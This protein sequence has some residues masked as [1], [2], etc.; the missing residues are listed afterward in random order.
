MVV[1]LDIGY[2]EVKV[3]S[4]DFFE[5]FP[6]AVY[7]FEDRYGFLEV[8]GEVLEYQG[9]KFLLSRGRELRS[10]NYHKTMEWLAL[11]L[12]S[13]TRTKGWAKVVMGLPVSWATKEE[14]RIL[15]ERIKGSFSF[16]LGKSK[17]Y[18]EVL[19]AKVLAQGLGVLLDYFIED[20]KVVEERKEENIIIFDVGFYTTDVFV[21][22]DGGMDEERIQSIEIGISNLLENLLTFLKTSYSYPSVPL[23][24]VEKYFRRGKVRIKGEEVQIDKE[25]FLKEFKEK[26]S[27]LLKFYEKELITFDTVILAGGGA[28]YVG[29]DFFSRKVFIPERPEFSNARGYYKYGKMIWG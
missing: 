2:G 18:V 23:K 6:S 15:Q 22:K 7:P 5:K 4:E 29:E 8:Q 1:G 25:R 9:R 11:F 14:R 13:L 21:Y 28:Y 16:S 26:L 3:W 12:K 17:R 20:G 24:E 10:R 19:D 27:D